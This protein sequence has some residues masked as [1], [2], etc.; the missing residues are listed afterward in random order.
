MVIEAMKNSSER[1]GG[2]WYEVCGWWGHGVKFGG[3]LQQLMNRLND[4]A[5]T[6]NM[7]I[8]VQKTKT[9]VVS[10]EGGKVVSI[11]IEGQRV[12]QVKSF[13]YLESIIL[14]DRRNL[15]DVKN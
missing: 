12:E 9:M 15:V 6:I 1:A 3:G 2:W 7:N 8:N 11:T 5:K 4:T 14:K 13:K 10:R